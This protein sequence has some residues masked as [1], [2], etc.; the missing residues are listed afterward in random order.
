MDHWCLVQRVFS[1][2]LAMIYLPEE[3]H[4][5]IHVHVLVFMHVVLYTYC[6]SWVHLEEV[7]TIELKELYRDYPYIASTTIR[8]D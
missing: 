7:D 8:W 4:H 6:T 1:P 2:S 5:N 3:M